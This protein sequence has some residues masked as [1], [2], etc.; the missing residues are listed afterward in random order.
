MKYETNINNKIISGRIDKG[1][2]MRNANENT[3]CNM[4]LKILL[5]IYFCVKLS[6]ADG[7]AVM[8]D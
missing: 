7:M 2:H 8:T 3:K 4:T 1:E 5:I 6:C